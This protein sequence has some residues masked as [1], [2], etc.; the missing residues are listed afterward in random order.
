MGADHVDDEPQAGVTREETLER[1]PMLS[2][3]WFREA[4]KA[5][6]VV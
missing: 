4:A 6:R 5:D 3:Q 1:T 2:A